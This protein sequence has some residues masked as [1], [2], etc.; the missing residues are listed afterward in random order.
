MPP[1]VSFSRERILQ[2]AFEI[3]R[4]DGLDVLSAREIGHRLQCSTRPVYTAFQS[5]NALQEAVIQK[6]REYALGYFLQDS[7]ETDSPFL[8]LG[9]RYFRLSQEEREL[10]KLLYLEGR[11]GI[12][13]EKMGEYFSP[14]LDRMKKDPRLHGLSEACLKRMGMARHCYKRA[15]L[16]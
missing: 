16:S 4:S 8:S 10:F 12:T 2:Q 3:V 11:I 7:E 14:L 13:F 9:L 5:M 1:K 15:P 6:A